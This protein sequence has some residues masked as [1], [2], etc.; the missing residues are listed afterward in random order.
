MAMVTATVVPDDV[1]WKVQPGQAEAHAFS[2]GPGWMRSTCREVRW[3]VA[4]Q[5]PPE[6]ASRCPSCADLVDGARS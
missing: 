1:A 3:T 2:A 4:L 6:D 5:E